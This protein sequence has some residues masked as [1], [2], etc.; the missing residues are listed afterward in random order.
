MFAKDG[1]RS[2][3]MN[4][5]NCL[6]SA[7]QSG[8]R[9]D[10]SKPACECSHNGNVSGFKDSYVFDR[11]LAVRLRKRVVHTDRKREIQRA[12]RLVRQNCS[13]GNKELNDL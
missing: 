10:A 13:R 3:T 4:S 12:V 11:E 8:P 2:D 9:Q 1:K 7:S 5:V 6:I